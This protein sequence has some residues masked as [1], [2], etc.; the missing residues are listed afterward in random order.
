MGQSNF[1]DQY[2]FD[3]HWKDFV[4][5][6]F[7]VNDILVST[8]PKSKRWN[9]DPVNGLGLFTKD[10]V[11]LPKRPT[12]ADKLMAGTIG[13]FAFPD[14]I[15]NIQLSVHQSKERRNSN[16]DSK[17][18][19]D[20]LDL[21]HGIISQGVFVLNQITNYLAL[22]RGADHFDQENLLP[23]AKDRL[24]RDLDIQ[25]KDHSHWVLNNYPTISDVVAKMSESTWVGGTRTDD[26]ASTNTEFRFSN[27]VFRDILFELAG[28]HT[29]NGL[30]QSIVWKLFREC[31]SCIHSPKHLDPIHNV[32]DISYAI[33]QSALWIAN[34]LRLAVSKAEEGTSYRSNADGR[35][36]IPSIQKVAESIRSLS[37]KKDSGYGDTNIIE[38]STES[39]ASEIDFINE[40]VEEII[41]EGQYEPKENNYTVDYESVQDDP[42]DREV[43]QKFI[44]IHDTWNDNKKP[45]HNS[46]LYGYGQVQSPC[47]EIESHD[48]NYFKSI[49]IE[50][51]EVSEGGEFEDMITDNVGMPTH[52]AWQLQYG[53]MD[54]F[55]QLSNSKPEIVIL[56]D[57]SSSTRSLLTK[58]K[59]RDK[60]DDY[61]DV[62]Q[63]E[64][65]IAMTIKQSYSEVEIYPYSGSYQTNYI[66]VTPITLGREIPRYSTGGTPTKEALL[67]AR[68]KFYEKLDR[69]NIILITDDEQHKNTGHMCKYLRDESGMRLGVIS[70]GDIK[71]GTYNTLGDLAVRVKDMSEI[72][73]IQ[74]LLDIVTTEG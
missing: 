2:Q 62:N 47:K 22:T 32:G 39:S 73:K 13:R 41:N 23:H 15:Y 57:N 10:N 29:D 61:T 50:N 31:P 46:R 35:V 18:K 28:E 12:K 5:S 48:S 49:S 36:T 16:P 43:I 30:A 65:S 59:N 55:K 56:L 6:T 51:L 71:S 58:E 8:S 9:T 72:P 44:E 38:N 69:L 68:K 52:N 14:L 19:D 11:L 66:G 33:I 20:T 42:Y 70:V 26:L 37:W 27:S 34:Y 60:I 21:V 3:K 1:Y 7:G 54:V 24:K 25:H 74:N 64:W 40:S 63:L 4:Q 53:N 45:Q 67:W 17:G